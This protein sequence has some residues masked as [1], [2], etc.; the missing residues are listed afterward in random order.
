[1]MCPDHGA[2]DHVG[3]R[4]TSRQLGQRLEHG[5]E[6][7]GG[8]PSSVAPEHTVPLAILVGQMP[9]LRTR[10]RNPHHAFEIETIILRG[11]ATATAFRRQ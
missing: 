1:M 4:F 2:I 11:A 8:D 7:A 9:P 10:P 3:G 5:I 6:Y